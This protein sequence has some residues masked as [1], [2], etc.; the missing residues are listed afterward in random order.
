MA[1]LDSADKPTAN[2]SLPVE[3]IE[4]KTIDK[5]RLRSFTTYGFIVSG[6]MLY[7]TY[8]KILPYIAPG[9]SNTSLAKKI[10]FTQTAFTLIS[11]CA[12]YTAIPLMQGDSLTE[13][14]QE[15]RYKLWPTL[16]TNWKVWPFLQLINF[17][18]VPMQLQAA[19]VAFFSIFFNIYLSFMKFV[20]KRPDEMLQEEAEST[21][22]T[23]GLVLSE[24]SCKKCQQP[25]TGKK[26]DG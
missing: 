9:T 21:L 12:F 26:Q 1:G 10:L 13:G 5:E 3:F 22:F 17:T 7:T 8:N 19:Y 6:P 24:K 16:V 2:L 4:K 15:I 20:I 23:P 11:M 18:F 14:L 25:G